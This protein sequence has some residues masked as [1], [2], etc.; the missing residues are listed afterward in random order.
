MVLVM[1]VVNHNLLT[2]SEVVV[3]VVQ[4]PLVNLTKELQ[5]AL[6]V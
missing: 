2:H 4:V 5:L 1:Q 3:E 6:V